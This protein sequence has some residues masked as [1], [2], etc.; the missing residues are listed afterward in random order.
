MPKTTASAKAPADERWQAPPA[1][2]AASAPPGGARIREV[3]AVRRATA[4][5]RHL[6]RHPDAMTVSRIAR[7]LDIIPSTCLHLLR[8]LMAAHLVAFEPNGKTYKL[9]LGLL[10]LANELSTGNIY[11]Q[12]ARPILERFARAHGVSV[13]AQQRDGEESVIVAAVTAREGFEAPLGYRV[14]VLSSAS[15][16]LLAVHSGWSTAQLRS[17]FERVRWQKPPVYERWL[18][19]VA[20]A[21]RDGHACDPGNFRA[22]ITSLAVGVAGKDGAVWRT[23]SVNVVSAQLDTER[24]AALLEALQAM[25]AEISAAIR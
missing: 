23:V 8:E 1:G 2:A 9:G 10:A 6:S 13:S 25:G 21:G 16:R 3:P 14:N 19:E 11:I 18:A 20:R 17:R 4:I 12:A 15:G 24:T 7:D 22:G 5:L